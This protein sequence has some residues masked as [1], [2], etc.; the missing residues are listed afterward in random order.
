[1]REISGTRG[2]LR[3]LQDGTW[4][5]E[6][7][8]TREQAAAAMGYALGA[9]VVL[10]FQQVAAPVPID[11]APKSAPAQTI[12]TDGAESLQLGHNSPI[13]PEHAQRMQMIHR[14]LQTPTF[15]QF[16]WMRS[17]MQQLPPDAV[18]H[19]AAWLLHRCGAASPADLLAGAAAARADEVIQEF[20]A[21]PANGW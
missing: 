8:L 17:G 20:K 18:A 1:M 2:A 9:V 15:Q 14:L 4:V 16:A 10:A 21:V 12:S 19:A 11:P 6:V 7:A 3:E 5:M 13:R